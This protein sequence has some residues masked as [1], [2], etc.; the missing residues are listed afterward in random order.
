MRNAASVVMGHSS[1]WGDFFQ[2]IR[3]SGIR[4]FESQPLFGIS[5]NIVNGADANLEVE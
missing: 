2:R 4:A 3:E 1:F 5:V